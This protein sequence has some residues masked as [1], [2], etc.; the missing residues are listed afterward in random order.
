MR[1][2]N[3]IDVLRNTPL[4]SCRIDLSFS[5]CCSKPLE[6]SRCLQGIIHTPFSSTKQSW[7]CMA[8][9]RKSNSTLQWSSFAIGLF[10]TAASFTI[11]FP[12]EH[13]RAFT[14]TRMEDRRRFNINYMLLI[15]IVWWSALSNRIIQICVGTN[16]SHECRCLCIYP[17]LQLLQQ[18]PA[19]QVCICIAI[20]DDTWRKGGWHF[21]QRNFRS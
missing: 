14:S 13:S 2:H 16:L 18:P 5:Q 7:W 12:M 15:L 10:A 17:V 1:L 3:T 6:V 20:L 11:S 9:C 8:Q 4:K 19:V 21:V